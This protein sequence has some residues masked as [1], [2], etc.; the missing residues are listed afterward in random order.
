MKTLWSLAILFAATGAAM[1]AAILAASLDRYGSLSDAARAM[2]RIERTVEPRTEHI[3]AYAAK[4]E[5]FKDECRA[6]GYLP[7]S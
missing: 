7:A 1:G 4:Y 5:Q 6:R 3:R 2:V